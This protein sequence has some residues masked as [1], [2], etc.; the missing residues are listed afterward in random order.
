MLR[1]E[2]YIPV[3]LLTDP[4]MK[5]TVIITLGIPQLLAV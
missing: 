3:Y 2:K 4:C 5:M 1:R